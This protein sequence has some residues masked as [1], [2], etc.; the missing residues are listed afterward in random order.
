MAGMAPK[1][2]SGAPR[3]GSGWGWA[4]ALAGSVSGCL[5]LG[6]AGRALLLAQRHHHRQA[7]GDWWPARPAAGAA[8]CPP[9]PAC[10]AAAGAAARAG[11]AALRPPACECEGRGS[12]AGAAAEG[13]A[14]GRAERAGGAGAPEGALEG[15]RKNVKVHVYD[16][17]DRYEKQLL[18][19]HSN[20]KHYQWSMEYQ[21][22]RMLRAEAQGPEGADFF[23]VPFLSKCYFNYKANYN[24]QEM[25]KVFKGLVE[26]L[27]AAHPW[28]DRAGGRDH[29]F[30]F[31]SGIGASMVPDWR[32]YVPNS[33]FL[34]AEGD[35]M[36]DYVNTWKDIIIPA[37]SEK[38]AAVEWKAFDERSTF[39]YFRGKFD[40]KEKDHFGKEKRTPLPLRTGLA[41]ILGGSDGPGKIVFTD[42]RSSP[43]SY[44]REIRKSKFCICPKGSSPWTR[45]LYDAIFSGCIPVIVRW[46][47]PDAAG[48]AGPGRTGG[49]GRD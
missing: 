22:P 36:K 19:D 27:R 34:V 37:T 20:C 12:G 46:V 18:K 44:A 5:A 28:W 6:L 9:C 15:A 47:A 14:G 39:I 10:P 16:L 21:I 45:R 33:I 8:E 29:I 7:H 24:R 3:G 35:R 23:L 32:K 17:P 31:P 42:Q 30:I 1:R 4:A 40:A 43:E 13:R 38:V 48:R 49:C 26:H 25:N 2:R 11:P 41:K